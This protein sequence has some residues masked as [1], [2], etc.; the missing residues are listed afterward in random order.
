MGQET[1][2]GGGTHGYIDYPTLEQSRATTE[3]GELAPA[4]RA[5]RAPRLSLIGPLAP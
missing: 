5:R 4:R 3:P 1:F 2:Y